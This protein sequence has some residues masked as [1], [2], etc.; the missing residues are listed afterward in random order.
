MRWAAHIDDGSTVMGHGAEV[1]SMLLITLPGLSL[2]ASRGSAN[3]PP[4]KQVPPPNPNP[5][6]TP[7][8]TPILTLTPTST[9]TPTLTSTPTPTLKRRGLVALSLGSRA[10]MVQAPRICTSASGIPKHREG[11]HSAMKPL[12][13]LLCSALITTRRSRTSCPL[14]LLLSRRYAAV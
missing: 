9:P 12:A 10:A 1:G 4:P 8:L 14:L 7:A 2:T 3:Y 11:H 6:P 13:A 5:I